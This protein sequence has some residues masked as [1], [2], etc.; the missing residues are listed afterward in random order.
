MTTRLWLIVGLILLAIDLRAAITGLP[1]LMGDVQQALALSGTQVSV[2][3]TL[4]VLCLGAF[5]W[6]APHLAHRHGTHTAVCTA[7]WVL[8]L[9]AAVRAIP[10]P[11][12]LFAGTVLS[13]AGIA[14]GNV[15]LPA[16]IKAHFADRMGLFTGLTMT[17]MAAS[18]AL[19]AGAAVPL[20]EA[21]GWM[22]ALAVWSIPAVLTAAVWGLLATPGAEGKHRRTPSSTPR[23]TSRP[24]PRPTSRPTPRPTSRPTPRPTSRPTPRPARQPKAR[25]SDESLLRCALAWWVS[26]FLGLVSLMFYVLVAWLPQIMQ[27]NGYTAAESGL[28]TSV[29]LTIGIPLGFVVPVTAARMRSQRSLV[30]AVTT[31]KLISLAGLLLSPT[32]GWLWICLLGAAT[33]SA[34]PLAMTLL[35]LRTNEPRTAAALSGMAQTL[36]YLLAGAGPLA[37]G[38]LHAATNSWH[39]PLAALLALLIPEAVTGL[40]A[41]RPGH[42]RTGT[43]TGT[44][45]G[46]R[47][48]GRAWAPP[49]PPA[50]TQSI[51]N[52][53]GVEQ[54]LTDS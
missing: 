25:P 52:R 3:A 9:G 45:G 18:G 27:A 43:G 4:P 19:A 15:L 47:G 41:A 24:T 54:V 40:L 2:L 16:V 1:P 39:A 32:L 42:V 11:T 21:A 22:S 6:L 46:D 37:T 13:G 35:G 5:A 14:I 50:D 28:M 33:G 51:H 12:A 8:A 20:S 10:S 29:M 34:F 48:R 44:G 49:R 36:G 17:L 31:A 53:K 30:A 38:L 7:A 26:A 23:P